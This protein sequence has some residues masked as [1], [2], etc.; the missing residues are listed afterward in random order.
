MPVR[1]WP[2][3]PGGWPPGTWAVPYVA[4]AAPGAVG[5]GQW[6]EGANCQRFAYG[7]LGLFGLSCPPLRSSDLWEDSAATVVVERPGP[8]DLVLFNATEDPFG[9]H[10]GVWMAPDEILHL[11]KEVGVPVVWP[12]AEFSRRARYATTVG[13]KRVL[14]RPVAPAI[15]V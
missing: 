15:S 14:G 7:V 12:M 3:P 13:F 6:L 8:L 5:P 11:C 1:S 9:A 4:S 10:L 2:L